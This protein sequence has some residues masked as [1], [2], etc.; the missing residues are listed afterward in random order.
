MLTATASMPEVP[1]RDQGLRFAELIDFG[2][3]GGN[4]LGLG[5]GTRRQVAAQTEEQEGERGSD[6]C[7]NRDTTNGHTN[8]KFGS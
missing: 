2:A 7:G 5:A 6:D 4:L 3:Q 8:S 1:V